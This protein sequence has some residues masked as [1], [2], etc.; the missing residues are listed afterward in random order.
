VPP[1]SLFAHPVTQASRKD[2]AVYVS[3]SSY[4]L[5]KEQTA[6]TVEAQNQTAQ[7][8]QAKLRRAAQEPNRP[9]EPEAL[10]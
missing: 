10:I 6:R 7:S 4:S 8:K 1:K 9:A 5:V 2:I 3:L